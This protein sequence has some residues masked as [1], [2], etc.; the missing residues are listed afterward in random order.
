MK[1]FDMLTDNHVFAYASQ[2]S[3][4]VI[5]SAVPFL[6]LIINI[7]K[8]VLPVSQEDF[9][10]II[11]MLPIQIQDLSKDLVDD[12]YGKVS[13]PFISVTTI[14]LLW[15]ASRGVKAISMGLRVAFNTNE[16]TN[17]IKST[18]WSLIYTV[19]FMVSIV[20]SVALLLF[21]QYIAGLIQKNIPSFHRVVELVLN[22]R[23]FILLV[24]LILVFMTAY[25]FLG[26]SKIKFRGQFVGAALSSGFWLVYSYFYSLYIQNLS[27]LSY[28]YGSLAAVVF[29]M[30]WIWFCMISL[31]FGAEV[32]RWLFEHDIS[33]LTLFKKR[34]KQNKEKVQEKISNN[35]KK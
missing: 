22:L 19:L 31:L 21:G 18:F 35:I 7:F 2:A 15:S 3:F 25:K 33:I 13:V 23:Y 10:N 34:V 14:F 24:F 11:E 6:M 30:L 27:S 1:F 20:V 9:Y 29:L 17:Y 4:F 5:I 8:M 28:I 26:K 32:N 16:E 12:F